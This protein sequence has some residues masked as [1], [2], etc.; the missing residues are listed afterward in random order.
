MEPEPCIEYY[1][2]TLHNY[3]NFLISNDS[4]DDTANTVYGQF[5][6]YN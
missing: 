1:F 5:A 3:N 2:S 4:Y 6:W